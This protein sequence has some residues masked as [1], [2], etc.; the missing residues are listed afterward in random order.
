MLTSASILSRFS[1]AFLFVGLLAGFI[2]CKKEESNSPAPGPDPNP[3]PAAKLKEFRNGDEF[4]KFFYNADGTVQKVNVK[5]ELN[6]GGEELTYNITYTAGKKIASLETTTGQKIVP[7][8]TNNILSKADLFVDGE[9]AGFTNYLYE[10][11]LMKRATIYFGQGTDFQPFLEFNF[12]YNAQGNPIESVAMMANGVP[13]QLVR[14]GHVTFE[15]D[16]KT[17]PLY[18][19]NEILALF[20]QGAAKNNIKK[21]EHFDSN[22]QIEDRY[23]YTYTYKTNG[24][25]ENAV[26][27]SGLPGQPEVTTNIQ[28]TYQ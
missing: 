14:A 23:V 28:Y 8:Y 27:K 7:V 18:A 25:P 4:I 21:E 26:V 2:A 6:T 16:Q 17:N 10:Q 9:K 20:W 11:G 3:V 22:L 19:Q 13:G 12:T 15:Y 5:S 24:L 1:K